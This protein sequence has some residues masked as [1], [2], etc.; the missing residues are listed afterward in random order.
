M[1]S[2][3]KPAIGKPAFAK[4]LSKIFGVTISGRT[5]SWNNPTDGLKRAEDRPQQ[6][7]ERTG[8]A[9]KSR[10]YSWASLAVVLTFLLTLMAGGALRVFGTDLSFLYLAG[11]VFLRGVNPYA[12]VQG[13]YTPAWSLVLLGP[14]SW[15]P[16]KTALALWTLGALATWCLVLRKLEVGPGAT[17]LF[18]LNPFLVQGL[19]LGSYDWLALLGLLMPMSAG[20]WLLFL[21]PQITLS[22]LVLW[23]KERG[24]RVALRALW[25]VAVASVVCALIGWWRFP[26]VG[27]MTWNRSLGWW[28]VPVGLGLLGYAL[29][30]DDGLLA[31][32]AAPFLSPY[33]GVQSWALAFLPLTRKP[34]LLMAGVVLAWVVEI[35]LGYI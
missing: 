11:E 31:L 13:F 27:E 6:N 3:G 8:P 10:L 32:A 28:G 21:K 33:V 18:L 24:W 35:H 15:L 19:V 1:N 34:W 25:P 22:F 16:W 9:I 4:W 2:T 29:K 30:K 5:G 23:L 7:V 12:A 26:A 17:A 20:A 14:L